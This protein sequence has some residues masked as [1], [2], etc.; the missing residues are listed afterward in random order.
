VVLQLLQ[1]CAGNFYFLLLLVSAQ[2]FA[3]SLAW[4]LSFRVINMQRYTKEHL[5][6]A[7]LETGWYWCKWT[8]EAKPAMVRVSKYSIDTTLWDLQC[9]VIH[10]GKDIGW[11]YYPDI[12]LFGP[13]EIPE[14]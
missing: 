5:A 7:E 13:I 12:S 8:K 6:K 2:A 14:F 3:L 10:E 4:F 11:F 1:G 9:Y